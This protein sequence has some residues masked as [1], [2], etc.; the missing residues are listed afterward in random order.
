[1]G[2]QILALGCVMVLSPPSPGVF[3][4]AGEPFEV[5]SVNVNGGVGAEVDVASHLDQVLLYG[6]VYDWPLTSDLS[7]SP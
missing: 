1:M 3:A 7:L 2:G 5:A 6:L 4:T